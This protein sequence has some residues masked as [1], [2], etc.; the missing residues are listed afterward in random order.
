MQKRFE[1]QAT[2]RILDA[3]ETL[4]G[5][6]FSAEDIAEFT[7]GASE[8]DLVQLGPRGDHV[9]RLPADSSRCGTGFGDRID[10]RTAAFISA[11]DKIATTYED[12]G[13]FP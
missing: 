13:I 11:I 5:K 12:L 9:Q 8:K 1:E 3:I 4:T 10:L 6:S 7:R 2:R